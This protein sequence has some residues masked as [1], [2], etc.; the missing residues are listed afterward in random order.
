MQVNCNRTM[1]LQNKNITAFTS[2]DWL[3]LLFLI[4]QSSV[5]HPLMVLRCN[6]M[7]LFFMCC[8]L[9]S[10]DAIITNNR[11]PNML[12]KMRTYIHREFQLGIA[13]L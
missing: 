7:G 10:K 3:S 2:L 6:E 12:C 1:I 9:I 11:K 8:A 5:A 4:M 13:H